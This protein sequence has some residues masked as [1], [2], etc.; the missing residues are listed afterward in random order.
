MAGPDVLR[1]APSL[2]I[3]ADDMNEGLARFE[4][5]IEEVVGATALAK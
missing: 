5:A 3:S 2:I 4:K 1:F